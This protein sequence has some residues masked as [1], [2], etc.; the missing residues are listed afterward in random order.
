MKTKEILM[1]HCLALLG[2]ALIASLFKKVPGIVKNGSFFIAIVLLAVSQ[3]LDETENLELDSSSC[4]DS[5]QCKGETG[6][7]FTN[8]CMMQDENSCLGVYNRDGPNSQCVCCPK[9]MVKSQAWRSYGG[10]VPMDP[11]WKKAIPGKLNEACVKP[12]PPSK[13]QQCSCSSPVIWPFS[14]CSITCGAKCGD[15]CCCDGIM[16]N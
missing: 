13:C 14:G 9:G 11:C 16:C 6:I 4:T 8:C 3:V 7:A 15:T 1:I 2:I 12:S 5:N 10:G